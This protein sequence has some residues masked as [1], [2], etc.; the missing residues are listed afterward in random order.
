MKERLIEKCC[1]ARDEDTRLLRR[2]IRQFHNDLLDWRW[3]T[4]EDVMTLLVRILQ[5]LQAIPFK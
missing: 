1:T 3:E 5:L 2:L 4:L